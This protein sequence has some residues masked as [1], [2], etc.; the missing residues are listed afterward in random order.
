MEVLAASS[1]KGILEVFLGELS[2]DEVDPNSITGMLQSDVSTPAPGG[3]KYFLESQG[4]AQV[5]VVQTMA[6]AE[7]DA[8]M[9]VPLVFER[10]EPL[11]FYVEATVSDDKW[12]LSSVFALFR[13]PHL[14]GGIVVQPE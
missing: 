11:L 7:Y 6:L 10:G 13:Q 9:I 2:E 3:I 14:P 4:A 5:G 8:S 1:F 12:K